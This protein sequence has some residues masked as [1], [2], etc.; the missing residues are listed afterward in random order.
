MP[1]KLGRL[2]HMPSKRKNTTLSPYYL[3]RPKTDDNQSWTLTIL[4]AAPIVYSYL[5]P[6]FSRDQLNGPV[7]FRQ[8]TNDKYGMRCNLLQGSSHPF[9]SASTSCPKIIIII[10]KK[11]KKK[12]KIICGSSSDTKHLET[13]EFGF[14]AV[15]AETPFKNS[16]Q[17]K[18]TLCCVQGK[19]LRQ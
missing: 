18:S 7:A 3:L 4:C 12:K 1:C 11:K 13:L 8:M 14:G 15:G 9:F 5:P 6:W 16:I 10:I 17:F 19:K 2:C